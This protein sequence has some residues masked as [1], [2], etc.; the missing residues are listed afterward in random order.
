MKKTGLAALSVLLILWGCGSKN[1]DDDINPY[2]AGPVTDTDTRSD[3]EKELSMIQGCISDY[4]TGRIAEVEEYLNTQLHPLPLEVSALPEIHSLSDLTKEESYVENSNSSYAGSY[5]VDDKYKVIFIIYEPTGNSF[6]LNGRILF[7]IDPQQVTVD[8]NRFTEYRTAMTS[9][10]EQEKR[11]LNWLYGLNL[12]LSETES[13][14]GYYE[15]L[16]MGGTTPHS[17]DDI[18]NIAERVFTRDFLEENFYYSAF[19]SESAMF[20]EADGKVY[21]ARS[22]MIAQETSSVYNP[23]YIIAAEEREGTIYLDMLADSIGEVQPDIKRL[24]MVKTDNGYRLPA[25]Y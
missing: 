21:C 11:V 24:T 10:L 19:Y 22:D 12:S 17:I 18:R 9:L 1:K 2:D 6:W 16:S 3:E 25:A 20:R 15:V 14:P 5:M 7:Q 23:R 4:N 8:D 13:F